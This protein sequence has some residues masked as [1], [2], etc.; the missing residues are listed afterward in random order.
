MVPQEGLCT[1]QVLNK[2][3]MKVTA[4]RK[5]ASVWENKSTI[6]RLMY[7]SPAARET[8]QTLNKDQGRVQAA[9]ACGRGWLR[10]QAA[11]PGA[12]IHRWKG[13][14]GTTG[15]ASSHWQSR[16]F[17]EW[18]STCLKGLVLRSSGTCSFKEPGAY[19]G[20]GLRNGDF[21]LYPVNSACLCFWAEERQD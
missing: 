9:R 1:Q 4:L 16:S 10:S 7:G 2:C 11:E 6:C 15:R 17:R 8:L 14:E 21:V 3:Y 18:Q 19:L 13:E 20:P 12:L 5:L